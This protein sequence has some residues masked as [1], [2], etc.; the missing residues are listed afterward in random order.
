MI[1]FGLAFACRRRNTV[2]TAINTC[3]ASSSP[4]LAAAAVTIS[5]N[6]HGIYQHPASTSSRALRPVIDISINTSSKDKDRDSNSSNGLDHQYQQGIRP[7]S[8][9]ALS[10]GSPSAILETFQDW[11]LNDHDDSDPENALYGRG[12]EHNASASGLLLRPESHGMQEQESASGAGGQPR[13]VKED[14]DQ[15]APQTPTWEPHG[16]PAVPG[17]NVSLSGGG[18]TYT[19]EDDEAAPLQPPRN[20]GASTTALQFARG[21][22]ESESEGVASGTET[23]TPGKTSKFVSRSQS[24]S[25]GPVASTTAADFPDP[26]PFYI[27]PNYHQPHQQHPAVEPTEAA[28]SS[29]SPSKHSIGLPSWL[30]GGGS[31]SERTSQQHKRRSSNAISL[32]SPPPQSQGLTSARSSSS[33]TTTAAAAA[34]P[35][36][37]ASS[38]TS[39][40]RKDSSRR[41]PSPGVVSFGSSRI[42]SITSSSLSSLGQ[43]GGDGLAAPPATVVNK[44]S[45]I[46]SISLLDLHEKRQRQIQQLRENNLVAPSVLTTNIGMGDGSNSHATR[47]SHSIM[48]GPSRGQWTSTPPILRHAN[49]FD[50]P[51]STTSSPASSVS[52]LPSVGTTGT[53]TTPTRSPGKPAPNLPPTSPPLSAAS[54]VGIENPNVP[55]SVF[56]MTGNPGSLATQRSFGSMG[57]FS[58]HSSA[59][60]STTNSSVGRTSRSDSQGTSLTSMISPISPVSAGPSAEFQQNENEAAG[61]MRSVQERVAFVPGKGSGTAAFRAQLV[62]QDQ[63]VSPTIDLM[64]SV[65]FGRPHDIGENGQQAAGARSKPSASPD[66]SRT[67]AASS[68]PAGIT[69]WRAPTQTHTGNGRIPMAGSK[70]GE[71]RMRNRSTTMST[72]ITASSAPVGNSHVQGSDSTTEHRTRSATVASSS[73][74][75]FLPSF[76]SGISAS[77]ESMPTTNSPISSVRL[78]LEGPPPNHPTKFSRRST[79]TETPSLIPSLVQGT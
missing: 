10:I 31:S 20:R 14:H 74:I 22:T 11:R 28:S 16:G 68:A 46:H 53:S 70:P 26:P 43:A 60:A 75:S 8:G 49:S 37:A 4:S 47:S 52:N 54:S 29:S 23:P 72:A 1:G 12:S 76:D 36:S 55:A 56:P 3:S 78:G 57:R 58:S 61:E 73:L 5:N 77:V 27:L 9:L 32:S 48:R 34:R 19:D 30:G 62:A 33:L 45:L 79:T 25:R 17:S 35:P 51:K 64:A 50:P 71:N 21:R 7:Q 42:G 67:A 44:P 65:S 63:N 13:H 59:T 18:Y 24:S 6:A 40:E 2:S 41:G 39:L 66:L 38:L 69:A 15:L